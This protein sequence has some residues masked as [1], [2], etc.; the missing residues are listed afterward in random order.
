VSVRRPPAGGARGQHFLRSSRLADT[1]VREAGVEPGQLVVDLGAGR[2]ALTAAL[3][4]AGAEVIAV[5]RDS[6]LGGELR[7]R[8]DD[9]RVVEADA[10]RWTWPAEPFAVVA[11]LPFAAASAILRSLLDDPRLPLRRAHLIVQWEL[12]AKRTAAWPSTLRSVHWG[13]WWELS[14]ARRLAASAFAPA[15]PVVAA[16]LAVERREPPLLPRAEWLNYRSFLEGLWADRPLRRTLPFGVRELKRLADSNGFDER[17]LPRDLD[18]RQW[19]ALYGRYSW[20]SQP[21]SRSQA[22]SS[23][24]RGRASSRRR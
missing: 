15:P 13:A 9:V 14:I 24:Q 22:A 5:E 17:A 6:L 7:A 4:R 20:S 12:A 23:R 2:G 10:R 3:L 1:L 18:A 8:F 11:N 16:V 21:N 19:A